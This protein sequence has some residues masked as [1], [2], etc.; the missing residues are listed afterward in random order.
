MRIRAEF[1]IRVCSHVSDFCSGFLL[2]VCIGPF[3][4][5]SPFCCTY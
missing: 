3:S 4:T 1:G 2:A 5:V